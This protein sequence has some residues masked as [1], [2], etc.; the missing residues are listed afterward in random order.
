MQEIERETRGSRRKVRKARKVKNARKARKARKASI[1]RKH[2]EEWT[3][4]NDHTTT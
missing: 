2:E 4:G 3:M 1:K